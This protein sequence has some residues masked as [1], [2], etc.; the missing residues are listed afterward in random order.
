MKNRT[1]RLLALQD[2]CHIL[3]ELGFVSIIAFIC[4]HF[5]GGTT[6]GFMMFENVFLIFSLGFGGM[7]LSFQQ[8]DRYITFG[9]CRK[10]F[11]KDQLILCGIRA[12]M[13][14]G[15]I[16]IA[17][18]LMQGKD[19]SDVLEEEMIQSY[20]TLSFAEIFMTDFIIFYLFSLILLLLSTGVLNHQLYQ[21]V[22]NGKSPQM[23]VRIHNSKKKP[24]WTFRNL[25]L[26][27]FSFIVLLT[28]TL[29]FYY[30]QQLQ[31]T[32]SF[33]VRL[34][35]IIVFFLLSVALILVGKKRFTPKYI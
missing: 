12:F 21:R 29:G 7:K 27:I 4:M 25:L 35:V 17:Q 6:S 15:V 18:Y 10:R 5:D 34:V 14:G 31:L 1:L 26:K 28:V 2:V 13:I 16:G 24:L 23:L 30:Y 22:E 33:P 8:Y 9:F 3:V 32:I 20:H 19:I 11:Y